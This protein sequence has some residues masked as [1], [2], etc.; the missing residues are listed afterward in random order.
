MTVTQTYRLAH[1]ARGKLSAE[2]SRGEYDLRVLV[3]H[4]NLLDNIMIDLADAEKEQEASYQSNSVRF[5]PVTITAEE[6]EI[7]EESDSDSDDED[8][9]PYEDSKDYSDYEDEVGHVEIL[10]RRTSSR[11]SMVA[12]AEDLIEEDDGEEEYE[13]YDYDNADLG[14]VRTQSHTELPHHE[15]GVPELVHDSDDSDDES[16]TSPPLSPG[17]AS[18]VVKDFAAVKPQ[19]TPAEALHENGF[20]I[21]ERQQA[22]VA[23]C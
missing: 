20:W 1:T 6:L 14:L 7:P 8:D 18:I 22:M 13:D 21:P 17:Y 15:H 4:A 2:A 12:L 23:A 10:S 5:A 16:S 11:P 3:G 19:S 9:D